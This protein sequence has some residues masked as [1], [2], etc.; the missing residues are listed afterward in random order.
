MIMAEETWLE[1]KIRDWVFYYKKIRLKEQ[2]FL[3]SEQTKD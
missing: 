2:W 1:I 3:I